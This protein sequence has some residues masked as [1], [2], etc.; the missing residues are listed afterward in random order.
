MFKQALVLMPGTVT[1]GTASVTSARAASPGA[2]QAT[3][4][5]DTNTA[6]APACFRMRK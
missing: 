6:S 3:S 1:I 2:S 5:G 4:V